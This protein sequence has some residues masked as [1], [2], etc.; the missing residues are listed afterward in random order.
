[1]SN[2][3]A[4]PTTLD[5]AAD[6]IIASLDSDSKQRLLSI[7]KADLTQFHHGWG[8]G[9]RNELGLWG[10]NEALLTDC[11]SSQMHADDASSVVMEAVWNK[12]H[13]QPVEDARIENY[14]SLSERMREMG[15]E[16]IYR[17]M[18]FRPSGKRAKEQNIYRMLTTFF[19]TSYREFKELA[20]RID[21]EDGLRDTDKS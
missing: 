2:S 4:L 17:H 18:R 14:R 7:P 19:E 6:W 9:I 10:T 8:T 1:M 15:P 13:G 16:D 3:D 21:T 12:L 20:V 5:A 11:G